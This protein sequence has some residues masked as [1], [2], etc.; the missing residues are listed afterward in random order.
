MAQRMPASLEWS[1]WWQAHQGTCGNVCGSLGRPATLEW[2]LGARHIEGEM[3]N[4]GW[5]RG[6]LRRW[7]GRL[8]ARHIA[9]QQDAR[10]DGTVDLE[11]RTSMD[12]SLDACIAGMVDLEPGTTRDFF[13]GNR[14]VW[15]KTIQYCVSRE[16]YAK[17]FLKEEINVKKKEKRRIST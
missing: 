14:G 6:C 13:V 1:T 10:I 2:T 7:N 12:H 11:T 5:R 17:E 15:K 8:G 4:H 9:G 3:T 16:K